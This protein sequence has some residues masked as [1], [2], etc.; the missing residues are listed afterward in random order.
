M[1][2]GRVSRY[3]WIIPAVQPGAISTILVLVVPTTVIRKPESESN[4]KR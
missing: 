3:L 1:A 4:S 2:N